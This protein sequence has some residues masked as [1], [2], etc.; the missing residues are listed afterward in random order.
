[1]QPDRPDRRRV[2]DGREPPDAHAR[3]WAAAVQEAGGRGPELR[4]R[5]LPA[6]ARRREDRAAVPQAPPA[7]AQ[8]G[9]AAGL[10]R[11]RAVRHRVPRAAQRAA[12]AG[13]GPRAAGPLLAA[14]RPAPGAGAAALGGARHRGPAR[15]PG[16][17]VHQDPP[18]PRRRRLGDAAAAE[19]ALHRPR[20]ARHARPVGG[21]PPT[22]RSKKKDEDHA[23]QRGADHGPQDR[24]RHH[25]RGG[26]PARRPGQD[27][28]QQPQERDLRR[29]RSTP[30]GRSSTRPS[31]GPGA[32][33]P[34]TGRSSG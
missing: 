19:R 34:R 32:S 25:R 13:P 18:R 5:A 6:D 16:R 26:R 22:A 8:G 33:P 21:P 14:A 23:A 17:D 20:P 28:A 24:A 2:P 30:R 31:P 9:R 12:Q 3:G 4:H 15:R 29:C 1:M 7:V 11:G 27:A 10:G